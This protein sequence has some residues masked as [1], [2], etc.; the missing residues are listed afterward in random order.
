M[1]TYRVEVQE[2]ERGSH[3]KDLMSLGNITGTDSNWR[4]VYGQKKPNMDEQGGTAG[5]IAGSYGATK[6]K[7]D[8]KRA[9]TGFWARKVS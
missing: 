6:H 5:F 4:A 9:I 2:T 1:R 8:H 7:K 3:Y